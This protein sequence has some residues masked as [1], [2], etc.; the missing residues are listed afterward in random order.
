MRDDHEDHLRTREITQMFILQCDYILKHSDKPNG[1]I[2]VWRE[3]AIARCPT[4]G[5]RR[6]VEKIY[7]EEKG[8]A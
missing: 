6:A 2:R 5:M 8:A 3:A 1:M 4:L 7:A